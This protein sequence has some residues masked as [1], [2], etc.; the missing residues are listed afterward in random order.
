MPPLLPKVEGKCDKCN[1]DLVG[2]EDDKEETVKQRQSLILKCDMY[3]RLYN[4][5]IRIIVKCYGYIIM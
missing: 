1:G 2:R 3:S 5:Y 4:R